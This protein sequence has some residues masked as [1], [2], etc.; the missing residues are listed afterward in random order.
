MRSIVQG[1]VIQS[2]FQSE[3]SNDRLARVFDEAYG[4]CSM[5]EGRQ[6]ACDVCEVKKHIMDGSLRLGGGKE[7]KQSADGAGNRRRNHT[8]A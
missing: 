3:R 7:P 2:W 6:A 4:G 5:S 8:Y 1:R